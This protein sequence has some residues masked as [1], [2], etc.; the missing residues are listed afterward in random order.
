MQSRHIFGLACCYLT[1]GVRIAGFDSLT[2]AEK[3]TKESVTSSAANTSLD[4]LFSGGVQIIDL[5]Y[6]LNDKNAYWPGGGYKP[7][8]MHTIATIEKD[9]VLSKAFSM[10][11]HLGT[12]IDAPNHFELN[13]PALDK[14]KTDQLFGPGVKLDISI[15]AE[16]NADAELTVQHIND[17]EAKH[18]RI[19]DGAI[20]MLHT[21]WGRFWDRYERYK[22]QD[23][24]GKLHFPS[25]SP[26]AA[27][28]LIE[29]RKAKGL[30]VDT[31]SIDGGLSKNFQ[32]HH[33]VN[34]AGKYG[35][36]NVAYLNKL[37]ARGFNVIVA[38]I[39]IE[40]GS[41]GPTRIFAIL[42]KGK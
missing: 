24:R 25:Y 4:A 15:L 5:T 27:R 32:V 6:K 7:F 28:F 33:I 9:G 37:P 42:P 21:G 3:P 16:Q 12:H 39:K 30:G 19:P 36:E 17:W 31:L 10:P 26:E 22:N 2:A 18:G 20:V 38:P 40:N 13:Q 8:H 11:E 34:R 41:G 14:I 35:L 1:L 29:T 23:V